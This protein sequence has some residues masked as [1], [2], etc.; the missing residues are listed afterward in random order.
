MSWVVLLFLLLLPG[1][2]HF[3]AAS[4]PKQGATESSL[5][6]FAGC[7]VSIGHKNSAWPFNPDH[8]ITESVRLG[9]MSEIIESNR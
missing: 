4:M 9:R 3:L 7:L 6:V 2:Q 1:P 8:I 5:G